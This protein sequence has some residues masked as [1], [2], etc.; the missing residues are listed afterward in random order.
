MQKE[1]FCWNIKKF[2]YDTNLKIILLDY[3][4]NYVECLNINDNAVKVLIF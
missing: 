1:W 3:Q 2:S 4:N